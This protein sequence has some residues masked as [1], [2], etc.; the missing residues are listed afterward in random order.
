MTAPKRRP[1]G[2]GTDQFPD[3]MDII[4]AA[5]AIEGI[6]DHGTEPPMIVES[7]L[8]AVKVLR[9]VSR[10]D[11]PEEK[12]AARGPTATETPS[13]Q[14][15]IADALRLLDRLLDNPE[16]VEAKIREPMAISA[17]LV[18]R[19]LSNMNRKMRRRP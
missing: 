8:I 10:L 18:E 2:R 7:L 4:G 11:P 14:Q 5:S 13:A 1:D 15:D 6:I 16:L 9:R 17:A 12:L 3:R 19:A